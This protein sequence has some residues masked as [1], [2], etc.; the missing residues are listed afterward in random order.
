M[1]PIAVISDV[2]GNLTALTAVLDDIDRRGVAQI[3]CLGDV[4]G[5]GPEPAKCLDLVLDRCQ[6][7]LMG[8]HDFAV[9]YEPSNFNIG[10]E[11]ACYWTR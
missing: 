8:N 9:L 4:V 2:H 7:T 1:D 11:M 10:A 6:V 5:Y 3:V